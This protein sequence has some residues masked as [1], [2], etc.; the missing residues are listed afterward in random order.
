M[1]KVKEKKKV[2]ILGSTGSIGRSA[3]E[4]LKNFRDRFEVFGL[5]AHRNFELIKNQIREFKP[6]VVVLTQEETY[7]KVKKE[8]SGK[9]IKIDFGIDNIG[10]MVSLPELDIV[11][12]A[13]VGSAGLLPSFATL[14][15]GKT[16]ALA[17]KESLVMAGELLTNIA[18][19]K[20]LEILPVDSEHSAIKQCLFAGKKKEVKRLIL[21]AS[22]GPFYLRKKKDLSRV[23]VKQA[24][25]HP[26]WEMGKKITVDSATLMNKGLEVIEAHWLFDIPASQM[27]VMI[28][29]QSVVHSMVEFVDGS[30]IAQM[31]KPDMKM[32]LQYALLYPERIETNQSFLDLTKVKNL[33]FLEPDLRRFPGLK[34]CYFALELG[35]TAPCVLNASNEVA[36]ESFLNKKISFDK[37]PLLVR[38]VL[39]SHKVKQN[40]G[41]KEI[42]E[43]DSWA[44][45]ESRS[46]IMRMSK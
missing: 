22:G 10:Q 44:K 38:K 1:R 28:H 30:I 2:V 16:L 33:T 12:N 32:P 26:N 24:L 40:P 36:V 11:I 4:V 13:I 42:L 19:K 14:K 43:A 15:A 46:L 27:K 41:L 7:K 23:T 21:T 20:R 9:R 25:S 8:F 39:S 6:E 37:I 5:S 29:P 18:K 17:N 34:L 35:G 31:S 45:E 3:L